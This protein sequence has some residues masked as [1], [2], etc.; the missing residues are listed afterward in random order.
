MYESSGRRM[1]GTG[2]GCREERKRTKG[3]KGK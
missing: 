3:G 1:K 2:E